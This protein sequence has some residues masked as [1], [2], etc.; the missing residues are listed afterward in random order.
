[1]TNKNAEKY[2]GRIE[3]AQRELNKGGQPSRPTWHIRSDK[4]PE[5]GISFGGKMH[6]VRLVH[7]PIQAERQKAKHAQD[8]AVEFIQS[9][10]LSQQAVGSLVKTDQHSMHQMRRDE[11]ER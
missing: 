7:Y 6:M 5:L 2:E 8:H 4:R 9:P 3:Q 1:A 11:D 10:A